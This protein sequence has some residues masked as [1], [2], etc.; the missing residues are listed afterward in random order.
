MSTSKQTWREGLPACGGGG[1]G[2]VCGCGCRWLLS[3]H[4]SLATR[5]GSSVLLGGRHGLKLGRATAPATC[6]PPLLKP[7]WCVQKQQEGWLSSCRFGFAR[8]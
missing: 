1:V 5:A 8:E 3:H 2:G 6:A 7:C 4:G